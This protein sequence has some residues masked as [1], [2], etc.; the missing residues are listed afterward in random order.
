MAF[1]TMIEKDE[2]CVDLT[3]A[4]T[5]AGPSGTVSRR[6]GEWY[7]DRPGFRARTAWS[8]RSNTPKRAHEKL[9]NK[10]SDLRFFSE[11][12][13]RWKTARAPRPWAL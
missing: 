13:P 2:T 7:P 10:L 12:R 1:P 3:A 4:S 9:L 6:F 8:S 5:I 11:F